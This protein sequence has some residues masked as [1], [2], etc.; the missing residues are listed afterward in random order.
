[1]VVS[2]VTVSASAGAGATTK[3]TAASVLAAVK[4]AMSHESGVHISV[5]SSSATTR[6]EATVD[7][8][9]KRGTETYVSGTSRVKIVV[10]PTSAYLSGNAT[11]LT[12]LVGLSAKQQKL[13]G[14]KAIE[15][16]VG[17]SPYASFKSNLTTSAFAAFLPTTKSVALSRDKANDY[18]LTWSTKATSTAPAVTSVLTISAGAKA[19]PLKEVATATTGG[20]TTIF[21]KWGESVSTPVPPASSTI[22]YATVSKA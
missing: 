8:G 11:G 3:P 18:V 13:V 19:L 22:P 21:S 9:T 7:I 10:T 17:T 6:S 14:T 2:S 15:M 5:T 12:S 16:K 1:M 4:T 20:G